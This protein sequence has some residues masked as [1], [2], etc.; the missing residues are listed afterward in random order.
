MKC[1]MSCNLFEVVDGKGK[2]TCGSLA[3][4]VT[5]LERDRM[6]SHSVAVTY[7]VLIHNLSKNICNQSAESQFIMQKAF[8]CF[9]LVS[10]SEKA[11]RGVTR[12]KVKVVKQYCNKN[13]FHFNKKTTK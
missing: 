9:L 1:G 12:I 13:V 7:E 3:A 6:V 5:K 2:P 4:L 10:K 11:H 8:L